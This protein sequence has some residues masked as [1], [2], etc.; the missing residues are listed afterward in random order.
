MQSVATEARERF[1]EVRYV[2]S[3]SDYITS[4]AIWQK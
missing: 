3:T 4:E 1:Q 2:K